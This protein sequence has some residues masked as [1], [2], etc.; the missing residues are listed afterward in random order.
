MATTKRHDV[1][2]LALAPEGFRVALIEAGSDPALMPQT[3]HHYNYSIAIFK[4]S[5][6]N[7]QESFIRTIMTKIFFTTFF[8]NKN[9]EGGITVYIRS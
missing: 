1:K 9:T 6:I 3:Y 2:D 7:T 8:F 5:G 4:T